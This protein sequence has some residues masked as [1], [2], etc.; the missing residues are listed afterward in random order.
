M[1]NCHARDGP[2]ALDA[3]SGLR[4]TS[5]FNF[6]TKFDLYGIVKKYDDYPRVVFISIR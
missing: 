3:Q 1:P 4:D 6:A 2:D 5:G